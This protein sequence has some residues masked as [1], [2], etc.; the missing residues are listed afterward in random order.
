MDVC[1]RASG[2][3]INQFKSSLYFSQGTPRVTK[4]LIF[5]LSHIPNYGGMDKYLGLPA[6]ISKSKIATF[7]EVKARVAAKL[8]SWKNKLLSHA[9]RSV[10]I[11]ATL[12]FMPTYVMSCFK[13]P[14]SLYK[15][16]SGFFSRFWWRCSNNTGFHWLGWNKMCLPKEDGGLGLRIL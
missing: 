11:K 7:K 1:G 5:G 12:Q 2:Q 8:A 14:G 9:G 10:L 15:D 4:Q 16:L 3:M 6:I 13:M